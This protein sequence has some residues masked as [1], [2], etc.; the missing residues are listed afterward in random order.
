[1]TIGLSAAIGAVQQYTK[2]NFDQSAVENIA[3]LMEIRDNA[4]HF[5]NAGMGL[6]KHVQEIGAATLRNFSY[7]VK[8]WF[9][10]DLGAYDFALMACTRFG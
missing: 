1:M 6:R 7:A 8:T 10:R 4:I 5:H 3:L 2:D 9:N